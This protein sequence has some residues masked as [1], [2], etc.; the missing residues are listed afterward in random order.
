MN[1]G[2]ESTAMSLE[3]SSSSII[4]NHLTVATI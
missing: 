3:D 2:S 1:K 4:E